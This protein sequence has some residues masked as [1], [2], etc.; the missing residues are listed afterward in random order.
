MMKPADLIE[1]PS[2][3]MLFCAALVAISAAAGA[4]VNGWRIEAGYSQERLDA[5]GK[6]S[7]LELRLTEQTGKVELMRQASDSANTLRQRAEQEA[8]A[9]RAAAKK[10]DDW[11]GKLQGTCAENLKDS[12]GKL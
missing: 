3:R 5:A 10:R 4:V 9:Q 1:R 6:I 12:W 7:E 11:I 8:I 2:F